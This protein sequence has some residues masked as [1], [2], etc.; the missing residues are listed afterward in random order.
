MYRSDGKLE[1]SAIMPTLEALGLR[2][3]EEVPTR[4]RNGNG[5]LFIHDFGVLDLDGA[6]LDLD[7]VAERVAAPLL[8]CSRVKPSPIR[9]TD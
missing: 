7:D 5:G 4:L 3:V 2:V 9:S 8:R 6:M 1:L